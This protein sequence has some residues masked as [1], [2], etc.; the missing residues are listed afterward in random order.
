MGDREVTAWPAE[1]RRVGRLFQEDLVFP[2]LSVGGDLAFV[3]A[4]RTRRQQERRDLVE[5]ALR[6]VG[7]AGFAGRATTAL[8][9]K[10]R[11]FVFTHAG[12][13]RMP[14]VL[15]TRRTGGRPGHCAGMSSEYA[16]HNRLPARLPA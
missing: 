9:A 12:A 4:A 7:L 1:R 10:F 6:E 11:H 2:H 14:V 5:E 15:V 8:R 13:R 3:L 16:K